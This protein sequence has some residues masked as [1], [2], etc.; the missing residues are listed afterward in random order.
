MGSVHGDF[1]V[2]HVSAVS[3][4]LEETPNGFTML[5]ETPDEVTMLRPTINPVNHLFGD[6]A[7]MAGSAL[8]NGAGDAPQK[9]TLE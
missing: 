3:A 6:I 2:A 8:A 4:L 9:E 7:Y 5:E 1:V